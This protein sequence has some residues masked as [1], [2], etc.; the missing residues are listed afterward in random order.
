MLPSSANCGPRLTVRSRPLP[1]VRTMALHLGKAAHGVAQRHRRVAL[2]LAN[3]TEQQAGGV[4][5]ADGVEQ[6]LLRRAAVDQPR[7]CLGGQPIGLTE[8]VEHAG[9]AVDQRMRGV[10]G[11]P[12]GDGALGAEVLQ[13]PPQLCRH[14]LTLGKRKL[15]AVESQP[16]AHLVLQRRA[17]QSGQQGT[18]QQR[19]Q[20]EEVDRVV[21][22]E[23]EH[24]PLLRRDVND[25]VLAG[26]PLDQTAALEERQALF[27]VL[28]VALQRGGQTH[29]LVPQKAQQ[30][31]CAREELRVTQGGMRRA[32]QDGRRHRRRAHHGS[33]VDVAQNAKAELLGQ[34][35]L[36]FFD[37]RLSGTRRAAV[38]SHRPTPRAWRWDRQT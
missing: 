3:L 20:E 26:W 4:A 15:P 38:P 23:V 6:R 17:A 31:L 13:Q 12:G 11:V 30:R 33:R 19:R 9:H 34:P 7:Q 5:L 18:R 24:D 21:L 28:R 8:V 14:R 1:A 25:A 37:R 32:E 29:A 22:V 16:P 36:L 2:R 27:E 10:D 35:A